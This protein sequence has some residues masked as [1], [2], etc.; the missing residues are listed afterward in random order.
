MNAL[1][2]LASAPL[3]RRKVVVLGTR[4]GDGVEIRVIDNGPG[5]PLAQQQKVFEPFFTTK[6]GGL[7]LG[8]AISRSIVEAHGGSIRVLSAP[9]GG[10]VFQVLLPATS[11]PIPRAVAPEASA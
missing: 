2:A 10:T 9:E 6:A 11:R 3:D 5:I 7:G 1:D 8:L 4:L